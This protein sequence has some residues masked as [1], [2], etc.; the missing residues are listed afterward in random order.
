MTRPAEDP[1]AAL[2]GLYEQALPRV[3]GY[4]VQ[5]G[6]GVAVA[7][8]LTAETFLA[9]VAAVRD[10][11]VEELTPAWLMSVAR[12][13]LVDHWRRAERERRSR[14]RH[15]GAAGPGPRRVPP[16]LPGRGGV[17]S[18]PLDE[19]FEPTRPLDPRPEFADA[20]RRR[21][22]RALYPED[23]THQEDT[24]TSAHQPADLHT[25]TPYLGVSDSRAAIA[26]YVE[27]F[28]AVPVG[29]PIVM[30]DGS[31]GHA[32][33]RIGDAMVFMADGPRPEYHHHTPTSLGG[34]TAAF[35]VYV[36]DVDAVYARA[37]ELGATADRPPESGRHR[38]R[39]G[40]LIDP[41]GHRWNISTAE[42]P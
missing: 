6:G 35:M 14:A 41:F 30:P 26:F 23:A 33:V 11:T 24:V 37:L 22:R 4:L 13:K 31:V 42:D 18:D 16:R 19:L 9:A 1:R 17:M 20:L 34:S 3:F 15:R 5:R 21:L 10:G 40:W 28:G 12:N 7:E 25:V 29:E 2:L 38:A 39:A 8:D 27:A 36:P 32:Q